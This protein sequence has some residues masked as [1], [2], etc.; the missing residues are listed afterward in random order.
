MNK[1]DWIKKSLNELK[2]E[3]LFI[4]I[5]TIESSIGPETKV[6]G[7]WVLNFSSNNYLGLANHPKIKS[8][9]KKA[10]DQ[11]GISP[12]AVRTISGTTKLHLEL[13]KEISKFKKVED[14]VLFQSG[15]TANLSVIPSIMGEN[16]TIFSDELNHASIIDSCRLSKAEIIKYNHLDLF[17]LE[18]KIKK[19]KPA[20]KK[21]IVS[22]G[23]FSMDGDIA[24]LPDIVKIAQ[25]FNCITM[26][27]DAHGE[28]VLGENGRGIVDH[29]KLHG[30]IDIEI[31]TLSKAFGVVGGFA[32]GKKTI[33]EWLKQKARPFL[34][35]S[36]M[37]IPDVAACLAAVKIL[38]KNDSLVKKLWKNT[39]YFKEKMKKFGFDIGKSQT[40]IT[41]IMIGD[42][43]KAKIFSKKLF[44]MGIFAT[45][46]TYPTVP[47]GRERIRVIISS[48]HNKSHLDKAI[49]I[50]L[51]VGKELKII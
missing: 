13:E 40:P 32:A 39:L 20:G 6:N 44:E 29:Y 16:D 36:A 21:L 12:C 46:I 51:K 27:D 1:L 49:K 15:F 50:F 17:D 38:C 5:K 28:G 18:T 2:R 23:V 41:P 10:I 26:I 25:K 34:F 9:A 30:K 33:I 11:Y 35:S 19:T 3:N 47:K 14:A 42:A 37:T 8:A 4:K 7:K 48:L 22:D 45:A 24:P 43:K 31:G